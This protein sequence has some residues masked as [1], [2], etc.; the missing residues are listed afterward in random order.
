MVQWIHNDGA[1]RKIRIARNKDDGQVRSIREPLPG[2]SAHGAK[3]K[4]AMARGLIHV[5]PKA[6]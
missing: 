2:G 4:S 6:D 3:V 1:A 5:Q